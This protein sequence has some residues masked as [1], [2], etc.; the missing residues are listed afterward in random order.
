MTAT[1]PFPRTLQLVHRLEFGGA[2]LLAERFANRFGGGERVVVA[3]L[4][5]E[6]PLA[7]RLRALGMTVVDLAR[8]PGAIDFACVRRLRSLVAAEKIELVH[9]HQTTPFFYA[10]LARGLFRSRPRILFTEHGRFFPD[11][12]SRKRALLQRLL[13]GRNDLVVAVG[14][15]VKQAVVK[16]EGVPANRV[17]VVYNGI[18]VTAHD[19]IDL[20]R[21]AVRKELGVPE[22]A[23]VVI[24]VA[25][26][27]ETKNHRMALEAFRLFAAG[28]PPALLI[29]V[30]DGP[31]RERLERAAA[32]FH[33]NAKVKFLGS[34]SDVRRLLSAADVAILTSLSEGIPLSLIEAM[35]GGLPIVATSVGGVP[36]VVEHGET[37][38]LVPSENPS[39][40]SEALRSLANDSELRTRL[41]DAGRRRAHEKFDEERM[42]AEYA[43]LLGARL[44]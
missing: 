38:L 36:E 14:E 42:F 44:P 26:L 17:H 32:E 40:L 37:G 6:G 15:S 4:D 8:R 16:Y 3:C 41:G 12:G 11:R 13:L 20:D 29:L 35:A 43:E 10:L 25:R 23:F 39:A 30:G 7:E 34:R 1:R 21:A 27:D 22:Q 18:P 33:L 19:G 5:G 31:E 2:E 24:Q 9:A 28:Y